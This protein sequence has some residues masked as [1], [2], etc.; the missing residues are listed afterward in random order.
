VG[1]FMNSKNCAVTEIKKQ[2]LR[3]EPRYSPDKV[4]DIVPK[5]DAQEISDAI[6]NLIGTY[7]DEVFEET[8]KLFNYKKG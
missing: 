6:N 7:G 8:M 4:E 2:L 1:G 3:M 5:S